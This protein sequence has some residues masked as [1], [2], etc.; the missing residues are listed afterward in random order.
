MTS[1][2]GKPKEHSRDG[3]G[4]VDWDLDGTDITIDDVRTT[5]RVTNGK[6]Q[7]VRSMF[8]RK[9]NP[10]QQL[11]KQLK[12]QTGPSMTKAL[13][14]Y[15]DAPASEVPVVREFCERV[16]LDPNT[17]LV[18][19]VIAQCQIFYALSGSAPHSLHMY[20]RIDGKIPQQTEVKLDGRAGISEAMA[21]MMANN[22]SEELEYEETDE[23]DMQM[24]TGCKDAEVVSIDESD[25]TYTEELP[26]EEEDEDDSE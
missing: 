4:L 13:K 5:M 26:E 25:V 14:M 15:L 23:E 9:G 22:V 10:L 20:D 24:L 6:P 17:C 1:F 12:A 2:F 8:K 3:E 16:G 19:D 21:A 11:K 7:K 18:M